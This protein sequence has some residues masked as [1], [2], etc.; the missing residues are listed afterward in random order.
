MGLRN[1]LI[2]EI[3][4]MLRRLKTSEFQVRLRTQFGT[5]EENTKELLQHVTKDFSLMRAR[6]DKTNLLV[7]RFFGPVLMIE[8]KLE[9]LLTKVEPD[10][11]SSMLGKKID[12][13]SRLLKVLEKPEYDFG[14]E[15]IAMYRSLI[16]PLKEVSKI[17]NK[18]AHDLSYTKFN[19]MDIPELVKLVKKLKPR[20]ASD[21]KLAPR[22]LKPLVALHSFAFI[23]AEKTAG[24]QMDL[25]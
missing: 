2:D 12:V 13:Y 6:K 11:A 20:F 21:I 8:L 3:C 5:P 1:R 23:V 4:K 17:R 22:D 15:E 18:M 19:L 10:I 7:G 14:A 24:L 25:T 16:A 9:N